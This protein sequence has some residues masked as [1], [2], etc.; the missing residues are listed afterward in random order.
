VPVAHQFWAVLVGSGAVGGAVIDRPSAS[1]QINGDCRSAGPEMGL[2]S[3][4]A[5]I[6]MQEK[7]AK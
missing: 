7:E 2:G 5:S 1:D 3:R 4:H 6:P